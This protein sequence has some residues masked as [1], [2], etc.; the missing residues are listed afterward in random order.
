MLKSLFNWKVL[1]NL[2]AAMAVFA[3]LVWL[4][5]RWLEKHTNHN[6]EV[7]V[8]NVMNKS[9]HE[10]IKIL[11]DA[12]LEYEVDSAQFDPK[13]KPFQVLHVSPQSGSSVKFGRTVNL[14]VNPRSWAPVAIPD[15]LNKH[16]GLAF[17]RLNRVDIKIGDTIYEPNIQKD[18]LIRLMYNGNALKPG[19]LI[20]RF[21][22][23]DAVI[24][25]GPMR[26]ISIP[27]VVGLTVKEAKVLI[28]QSMFEVGVV[29]HEDGGKDENDIVYYQDPASGDRRDQGMQIDLWASKKT[30]AELGAKISQLNAMYRVR[31]DTGLAPI[32]Y[33]EVVVDPDPVHVPDNKPE[34]VAP[35]QKPVTPKPKDTPKPANTDTKPKTD[36][37]KTTSTSTTTKPASSSTTK[38]ATTDKKPKSQTVIQ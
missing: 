23:V 9:V 20:P 33:E 10:A 28:A 3:G 16:F 34:V 15:V 37:K 35:V 36:V 22:T 26:N 14:R 31:V 27:R 38:P 13:F 12:G 19:T 7:P 8:P 32:R 4:T 2:L 1:L 25:T 11:E 18:A 21:S 5:F 30:P 6:Q 17:S 29:D 24:G